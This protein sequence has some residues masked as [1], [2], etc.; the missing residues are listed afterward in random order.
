MQEHCRDMYQPDANLSMEF[1]PSIEKNVCSP[2]HLYAGF[3]SA[4]KAG[5]E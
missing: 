3:Q 2:Y 4:Q 5:L 1:I